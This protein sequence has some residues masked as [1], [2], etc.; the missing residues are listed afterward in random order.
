[1]KQQ[2]N[3][4]VLN[5]TWIIYKCYILQIFILDQNIFKTNPFLWHFVTF[6]IFTCY[7]NF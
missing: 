7:P 3:K 6:D 4:N 2:I 1:M 5:M